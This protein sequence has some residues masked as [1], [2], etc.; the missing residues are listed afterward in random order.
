MKIND[1]DVIIIGSGASGMIAGITAKKSNKSVLLIE[2]LSNL[3]TKLKATGG[4]R[5]N[6]S[7][8]LSSV[9]FMSSFGRNGRFMSDALNLF[10]YKSLIKFFEDIGVETH[11]PDGF[12]IFPR[13]HNSKTI[14]NALENELKKLNIKILLDTKVENLIFKDSFIKG[15]IANNREFYCE[16]VI[17][18][19]GG[20][21]YPQL[22]TDGD[23][24]NF[25]KEVGHKIT[26]LSPA[27]LPLITKERWV[28][29]CK[30]DTISKAQIII[31]LPKAKK[32]KA[33]GDLIF[34]SNGIRGPVVLD[35]AREITPFLKEYREV[36]I[37]INMIKGVS[38]DEIFKHLKSNSNLN[39]LESL[40]S[41]LPKSVAI[42]IC[43][44]CNIDVNLKF[45]KLKGA[46]KDN[47]IKTLCATPL[48]IIGHDGFKKAMITRGGVS[49][50]EIN[51][52]TM[53]SKLINGLYFCGE[54]V[55]LDGPC[56]GYNLQWAFSS[57]Y[58]AGHLK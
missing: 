46:L 7:N 2:K 35:F 36:P 20:L 27:M 6:L 29:S 37:L 19:T 51:P 26:E 33:V 39:I 14:I 3:G 5:C 49:L 1:Y 13:T 45:N 58:L 44:L 21:G 32:L 55:D 41:L 31:N 56:G 24:Y 52:K 57:G 30:A 12:R 53:Q 38:E 42:E 18:A 15:V 16:K 54:V 23:G 10:D 48:T 47:L 28:D 22:G 17:V 40:N 11:I 8:T 9:E 4:G 43:K 25:A 50:K 34:T